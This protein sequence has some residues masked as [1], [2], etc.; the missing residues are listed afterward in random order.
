TC[1]RPVSSS[2]HPAV[3]TMRAVSSTTL[4][5]HRRLEQTVGREHRRHEGTP[6]TTSDHLSRQEF[7]RL[8]RELEA[9]VFRYLAKRLGPDMA[10]E[11]MAQAFTDAWVGRHRYSPERGPAAGWIW[12]IV[13]NLVK[14]HYRSERRQLRAY[15]R[16]GVDPLAGSVGE[17][18]VD[19]R[20]DAA[21]LFPKVAR[22]LASMRDEDRDVLLLYA[23][24]G[25][26]YQQI[27][28]ALGIS[29]GTVKSRLSR[30][31]A[32]LAATTGVVSGPEVDR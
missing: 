16:R 6:G 9:P 32:R 20:L 15:A 18:E 28:E 31:R 4:S 23:Y 17:P 11:L 5:P 26:G 8:Y 27:A 30:A 3:R 22:A 12:G 7:E 2:I 10:E 29:V 14:R 1:S 19:S 25:L 21:Q 13:T 24:A